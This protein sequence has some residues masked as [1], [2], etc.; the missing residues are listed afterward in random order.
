M[1]LAK[2]A[3][4]KNPKL[5]FTFYFKEEDCF[6]QCLQTLPGDDNKGKKERESGANSLRINKPK[7]T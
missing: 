2:N 5:R 1:K 3:N 7:K 4:G 6:F